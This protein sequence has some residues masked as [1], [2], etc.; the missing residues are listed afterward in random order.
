VLPYFRVG[1]V[2]TGGSHSSTAT[3]TASG[4]TTPDAVFSGGKNSKSNGFGVGAGV[5]VLVTEHV[6]FRGEFTHVSL[7]KGTNEATSCSA[8]PGSTICGIFAGD[9]AELNNIH[10]SFT[11]NIFRAGVNY[12]FGGAE[13]V[14]VAPAP[15]YVAPPPPPPKPVS[16]CPDTPPGL[17]VDKYGCPC[18]VTQEVHFA[19]NSAVL[20][21]Q[22]QALLDRMIVN[23]KR[24]NFING[25]VGGYTD[26]TGSAAYNKG[27]SERRAQAVADYLASHG[28]SGGRLTVKG[29]GA[30][31]P[32]ASNATA[33]GRAH[34]RRVVLHRTDC[35][36]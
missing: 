34:N 25:E 15:A 2:F 36:Q 16:L 35:S 22:D 12:K 26:S 17:A 4:D 7:G 3:Y 11:A 8:P 5:D 27:L 6:F 9:A 20:T 21:E 31:N 10:N 14:P 29:Y 24:L 18:D 32:V 30:D 33:E 1:G 19:T 23:M 28:I 13:P